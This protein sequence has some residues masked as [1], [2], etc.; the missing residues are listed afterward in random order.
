MTRARPAAV[1][2]QL[3]AGIVLLAA[4]A[5]AGFVFVHR[6]W[7]NRLDAAGFAAFPAAPL[8]PGWH[9]LADLGSLPVLLGGMAAG[10]ALTCWRDLARALACLAGPVLAVVVTERVAKPLVGRHL[11]VL[12]GSSFP[13]GTVTAVASLAAVAVLVAPGWTRLVAALPAAAAVLATSAAVVAL[14]WHFPTDAVGGA[15]VGLGTVLT[16]DAVAH[17]PGL[18]RRRGA[19]GRPRRGQPS[20]R[21]P[22][23]LSGSSTGPYSASYCRSRATRSSALRSS[24]GL[25][26]SQRA[27]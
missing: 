10:F 21:S 2:G 5:A 19:R 13:S 14:R 20:D 18:A 25:D 12:G 15:L 27:R 17:L 22:S 24:P 8:S 6:P 11:T 3:T 26:R 16:V 9:H 7:P 1:V 23:P 4:A